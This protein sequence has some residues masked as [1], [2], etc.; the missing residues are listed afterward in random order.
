KA[1][2]VVAG[3]GRKANV[4]LVLVILGADIERR[5]GLG[6]RTKPIR[7]RYVSDVLH[8]LDDGFPS[9]ALTR[10]QPSLI[11]P[12]PIPH[13]PFALWDRLAAPLRHIERRKRVTGA[14]DALFQSFDLFVANGVEA[15]QCYRVIIAAMSSPS[16]IKNTIKML[17]GRTFS[18]AVARTA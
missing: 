10:E 5:A 14:P 1:D 11:G 16:V 9:T 3:D 2:F 18:N 8:K 7:A 13:G 15:I 4:Q 6:Q 12:H 17:H